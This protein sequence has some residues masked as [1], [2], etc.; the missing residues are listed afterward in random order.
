MTLQLTQNTAT[1]QL[2]GIVDFGATNVVPLPV[3][4]TGVL[5]PGATT[6]DL[7]GIYF[8]PLVGQPANID[9]VC[10]ITSSTTIS[11]TLTIISWKGINFG[12]FYLTLL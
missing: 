4:V 7:N 12:S 10:T 1:G 5:L 9:L 8:D 6:F 2:D 11:G 3:S